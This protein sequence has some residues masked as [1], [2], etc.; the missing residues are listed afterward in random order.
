MNCTVK[1]EKMNDQV[2][3]DKSVTTYGFNFFAS[4]PRKIP[5][6][7]FYIEN[8]GVSEQDIIDGNCSQ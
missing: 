2:Y 7:D 8:F 1:L 5:L 4:D 3:N 6:D